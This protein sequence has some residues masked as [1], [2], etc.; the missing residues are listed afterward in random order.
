MEK[1]KGKYNLKECI[2]LIM[3]SSVFS[4]TVLYMHGCCKP[5]KGNGDKAA[6]CIGF[7]VID[8]MSE[9]VVGF[10][11]NIISMCSVEEV[12]VLVVIYRVFKWPGRDLR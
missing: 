4:I 6:G 2:Y 1:Q 3:Y 7:F 8:A 12:G 11:N 5:A 10:I 9:C